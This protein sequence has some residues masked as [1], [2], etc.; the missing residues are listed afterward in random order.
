ML[1]AHLTCSATESGHLY[2]RLDTL[3][4]SKI[5]DVPCYSK[6]NYID[7]EI[8]LKVQLEL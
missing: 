1:I 7:L 3:C 8:L 6:P 4:T 2:P 5:F